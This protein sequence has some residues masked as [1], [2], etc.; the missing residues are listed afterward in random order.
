MV[1]IFQ[2]LPEKG[3]A[4]VIF[5]RGTNRKFSDKEAKMRSAKYYEW[6]KSPEK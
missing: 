4:P 6:Q 2:F 5:W 1:H 3:I